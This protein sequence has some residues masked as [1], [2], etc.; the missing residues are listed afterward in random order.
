VR[1]GGW[2]SPLF[3]KKSKKSLNQR[4]RI[5]RASE[6]TGTGMDAGLSSVPSVEDED[7]SQ[8]TILDVFDRPKRTDGGNVRG[9]NERR[10]EKAKDKERVEE[11]EEEEEKM[12]ISPEWGTEEYDEQQETEGEERHEYH[13]ASKEDEEE[14]QALTILN[15]VLWY[16]IK[17]A[18]LLF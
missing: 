2:K 7:E 13:G 9:R 1:A 14:S 17:I 15:Q 10:D 18:V 6:G 11:E 8:S 3:S 5:E 16:I 4:H 12:Y